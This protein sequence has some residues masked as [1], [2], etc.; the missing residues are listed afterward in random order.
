VIAASE[1]SG[2]GGGGKTRDPT[3]MTLTGAQEWGQKKMEEMEMYGRIVLLWVQQTPAEARKVKGQAFVL[4]VLSE[5]EYRE[6]QI[7]DEDDDDDDNDDD[8]D[9]EDAESWYPSTDEQ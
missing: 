8:D 6:Q 5:E 3:L 4:Q 1:A 2:D 7:Y 9:D